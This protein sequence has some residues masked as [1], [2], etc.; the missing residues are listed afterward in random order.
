[1]TY[2]RVDELKEL[3][4]NT[5]RV[6]IERGQFNSLYFDNKFNI[7]VKYLDSNFSEKEE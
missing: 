5:I 2:N 1:M 3:I 7:I 4:L 6:S